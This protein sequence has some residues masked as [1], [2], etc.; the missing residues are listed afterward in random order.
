MNVSNI[1]KWYG[2]KKKIRWRQKIQNGRLFKQKFAFFAII[3]K[4]INIFKH[5]KEKK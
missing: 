2:L 5:I 1:Q 3:S 4:S